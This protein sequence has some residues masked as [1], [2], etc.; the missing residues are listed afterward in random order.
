[1]NKQSN[2]TP[3]GTRDKRLQSSGSGPWDAEAYNTNF[4]F[5]WQQATDLIGML[6]PVQ[7]ERILDIGCGTG[8]LTSD[9]A[10]SGSV[11]LGID[12]D[13]GMI[14]LARQKFPNIRFEVMDARQI[15]YDGEFDAVFSNAAL[16]WIRPPASV[17]LGISQALKPGGR[18]VV[19]F[20]GQG[21]VRTIVD[22]IRKCIADAGYSKQRSRNPWYFPDIPSYTGLLKRHGLCTTQAMLFARPTP[23]SG[24]SQGLA[25]WLD[26]FAEVFL[27]NV[28][29]HAKPKIVNEI[30]QEL[31]PRI[32][33]D[34]Q[35]VADYVRLRIVA[36]KS[37]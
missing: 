2:R 15:T 12:V 32:Y 33:Q 1:M 11:V 23:L 37:L 29:S 10:E 34:G 13:E 21:N 19:E 4:S 8:Q 7:G 36:T 24:G 26:M 18:L 3:T 9:I 5:V 22:A 30:V 16:H 28:P 20:G 6:K 25:L 17:V 14:N 35:W 27:G 31:R